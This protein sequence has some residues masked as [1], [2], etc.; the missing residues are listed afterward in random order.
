MF[1]YVRIKNV[2]MGSILAK[3]VYNEKLKL[4]MKEGSTITPKAIYM[5]KQLGYKGIYIKTDSEIASGDVN[6][7]EPLINDILQLRIIGILQDIYNNKKFHENPQE[8]A[9]LKNM[10]E[11][12]ECIEEVV[13]CIKQAKQNERLLYEAEDNR[14]KG[15]WIFYH[16][17][18]VCVLSVAIGTQMGLSE[19]ELKELG[20]GAVVHDIGKSWY[21]DDIVNS[22][23]LGKKEK[24]LL[25][26]HTT[27]FFR[28]LQMCRYPVN[29]SYAV[30]QHHEKSDGSG[31]P[32]KIYDERIVKTAKIVAVAN[33]YDN[34]INVNPYNEN[35][36]HQSEAL[37]YMFASPEF[38]QDSVKALM[39]IVAPY[40]VGTS[41]TLSNDETALVI[42]NKTGFPLRPVVVVKK[43]SERKFIDMANDA[44][45][46]NVIIKSV[47]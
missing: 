9:F 28:I 19:T 1:E 4:L 5:L 16:M 47:N 40:P 46:R 39:N 14:S 24:D 37:E 36:I 11:L 8:L 3:D 6:I 7:P 17:L 20:L 18:N 44:S 38:E 42:K 30:W 23:K 33:A 45:Y 32:N 12:E 10:R 2:Q 35:P 26:D 41:V 27:A 29:V 43:G 25:R 21:K 13:S 31:Y 15:N 34:K 22:K